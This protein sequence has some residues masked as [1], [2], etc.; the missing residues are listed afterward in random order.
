MNVMSEIK[1]FILPNNFESSI[2]HLDNFFYLNKFLIE[3]PRNGQIL[4]TNKTE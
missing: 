2:Y 1:K 4:N 3:I